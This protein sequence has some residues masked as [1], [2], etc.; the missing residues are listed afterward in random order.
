MGS[1]GSRGSGVSGFR[2][3]L[4]GARPRT[5]P[6]HRRRVAAAAHHRRARGAPGRHLSRRASRRSAGRRG[7][8]CGAGRAGRVAA[9]DRAVAAHAGAGGASPREPARQWLGRAG[10]DFRFAFRQL[11]RAPSFAAIAIA[12]LGLG[13]GAA[14]AIFSVVDAVLLKPLPFREPTQLGAI[15][16]TNAE[17]ALPKNG[18][19]PSTSWTTA[20]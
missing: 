16:E 18:C 20:P 5:R 2:A 4:E 15:W 1:Q 6:T 14:T 13:A 9:G 8:Q 10:G 3:R 7:I 11:R 19:P 17:K 12:T